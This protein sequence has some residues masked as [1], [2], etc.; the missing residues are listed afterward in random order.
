[1]GEAAKARVTLP[2]EIGER[3]YPVGMA[4]VLERGFVRAS[5][6]D[7]VAYVQ[8]MVT[9][10]VEA[11]A[12]GDGIYALLLTPKARVIAD[13][14]VFR[15]GDDLVLACPPQAADD[16]LGTLLRARFRKKVALEPAEYAL[17]WGDADGALAE[18]ATPVGVERLLATAPANGAASPDAWE[19]ARIEAGVPRFGHEFDSDSMPAEAGLEERAISF[20]KG[21]YPGQEPVARLHYRGHANRGVRGVRFAGGLANRDAPVTVDGAPVGRVTSV[22]DSPRFGPIGLAILRREVAEGAAGDADGIALTV[23]ALPFS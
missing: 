13:L 6:P 19:L 14:E 18:L 2:W 16:V 1:V 7:A 21:C 12:P 20:T 3:M 15:T 22:I 11:I 23:S 8:S 5:G 10:D 17:V 9:N 4:A